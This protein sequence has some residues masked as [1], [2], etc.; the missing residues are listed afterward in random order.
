MNASCRRK[1]SR[2]V[3]QLLEHEGRRNSDERWS[4]WLRE[5][6]MGAGMSAVMVTVL[7]TVMVSSRSVLAEDPGKQG[8]VTRVVLV[9]LR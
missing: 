2:V 7:G 4:T 8:T 3:R 9:L 5:R 1:I 6:E